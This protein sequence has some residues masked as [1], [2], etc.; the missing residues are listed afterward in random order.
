MVFNKL[1]SL[2]EKSIDKQDST[3]NYK[4]SQKKKAWKELDLYMK[5]CILNVSS[6]VG[7]N[8]PEDPAAS[9]LTIMS[10]KSPVQ[11]VTHFYFVMSNFNVSVVQSL[12]TAISRMVNCRFY[13]CPDERKDM[14]SKRSTQSKQTL[15]AQCRLH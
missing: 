8:P 4:R 12:A 3:S 10:K 14:E 7:I 13:K 6:S 15:H 9:L 5:T 2:I 1:G 11:F